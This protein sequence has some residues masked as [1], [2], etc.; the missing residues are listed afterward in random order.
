MRVTLVRVGV[1]AITALIAGCR[2]SGDGGGSTSG[3]SGLMLELKAEP[4]TI[5]VNRQPGG[6]ADSPQR[7]QVRLTLS[8]TNPNAMTYEGEARS[9]QVARFTIKRESNGQELYSTPPQ[10]P[11][12][13][14]PVRIGKGETKTYT[15]TATLEDVRALQLETL[16]ATGTFTPTGESDEVTIQVKIVR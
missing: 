12:V 16:I 4:S 11:T 3:A 10:G 14:T 13:I 8:V 1:L 9:A 7:K 2:G 15:E 5:Y 6:A